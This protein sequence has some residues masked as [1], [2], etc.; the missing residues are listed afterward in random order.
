MRRWDWLV[1]VAIVGCGGLLVACGGSGGG[2]TASKAE[3][4]EAQLEFAACMREHGVDMPDPQ[5]GEGG[6]VFKETEKGSGGGKQLQTGPKD[7]A[8][9]KALAACEGKLKDAMPEPSPEQE[10]EMKEAALEFA[11]CMREH[12][13]DMPDPTF[14]GGGKVKMTI[15]GPK[16]DA[17]SP[18]MKEAQEACQ[19]KMPQGPRPA[20]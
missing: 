5:A 18:L 4:E 19:D 17:N 10:E 2:G 1:A 9:K 14:E 7:P 15:R 6:L 8:T 13:I 11:Q 16:G 3:I 20:P 12:G